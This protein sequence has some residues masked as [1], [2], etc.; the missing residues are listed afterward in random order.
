MSAVNGAN[1]TDSNGVYVESGMIRAMVRMLVA[2]GF[3]AFTV[4]FIILPS[5]L[6]D[7]FG[8]T[9]DSGKV[10]LAIAI[11]AAL[12][13]FL[14]LALIRWQSSVNFSRSTKTSAFWQASSA[15]VRIATPANIA[16]RSA[17]PVPNRLRRRSKLLRQSLRERPARTSSTIWRRP[18]GRVVASSPL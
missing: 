15:S 4:L 1:V 10:D 6:F 14:E 17:D 8:Y 11:A 9:L 2:V 16:L 5:G 13:L 3:A 18:V 12:S 7:N